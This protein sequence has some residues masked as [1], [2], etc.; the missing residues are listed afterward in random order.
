[1]ATDFGAITSG[2]AMFNPQRV[3]DVLD[4][5]QDGLDMVNDKTDAFEYKNADYQLMLPHVVRVEGPSGT[6]LAFEDWQTFFQDAGVAIAQD[7][8]NESYNTWKLSSRSF[9]SRDGSFTPDFFK[10]QLKNRK[11]PLT[12]LQKRSEGIM[13]KYL[14]VFKPNFLWEALLTVPTTAGDYY[15]KFGALR[16]VVVDASMLENVVSGASAGA[17]NSVTRLHF[18]A[19]ANNTGIESDDLIFIKQYMNEY[20]G[21]DI[22]SLVM[23]GTM[24]TE[25]LL[26][27][28]FTAPVSVDNIAVNGISAKGI[29]GIPFITT[30]MLPDNILMFFIASPDEP[31]VAEL[32]NDVIDFQGLNVTPEKSLKKFPETMEEVIGSKY[33]IE[34]IGDHLIGRH[35]VIFLDITPANF[36][37]DR[38]MQAAGYTLLTARK[39]GLRA[40]WKTAVI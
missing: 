8:Y 21:L 22:N 37:A 4:N 7:D 31:I 35:K 5:I 1:M 32:V 16:N 9:E 2:N 28:V 40:Q 6:T 34:D 39:A 17:L 29:E 15:A 14:N 24:G 19:I 30:K 27:G 13:K 10:K 18:R 33:V 26:R 25:A 11:D 3:Q 38:E 23:V 20:V 36:N 12:I